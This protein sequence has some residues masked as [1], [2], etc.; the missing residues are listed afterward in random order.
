MI[1]LRVLVVE[2]AAIIALDIASRVKRLGHEVVGVASTAEMACEKACEA[3][4]DLVLMD[5]NLKGEQDGIEAA[6]RI[7][8]ELGI[9]SVFITAYSDKGMKERALATHP[10]GYIV[11]PIREVDLEKV[12]ARVEEEVREARRT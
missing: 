2:D 7:V 6:S 5:I 12:L 11:K 1:P 8:D 10:L 9:R 4:P 3:H